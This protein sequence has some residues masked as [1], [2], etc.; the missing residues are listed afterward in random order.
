M[1]FAEALS[2][3]L[4]DGLSEALARAEEPA[5]P[6]PLAVDRYVALS[7]MQKAIRRGH[8]GL[9]L[10]AATNLMIG[11]PHCSCSE[12]VVQ[13]QP[14]SSSLSGERSVTHKQRLRH[15]Q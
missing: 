13:P 6:I 5:P 15:P 9:A 14:S 4:I 2:E 10:R 8:E 11:G 12:I 7:A 3:Y 1:V